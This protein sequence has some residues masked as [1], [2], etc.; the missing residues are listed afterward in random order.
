MEENLGLRCPANTMLGE[1]EIKRH[2]QLLH[3]RMWK[4]QSNFTLE[5][6]IAQHR[7]AFVSMQAAA[8]HVTYQLPNEH[9]RVEYLLDAIQCNDAGPDGQCQDRPSNQWTSK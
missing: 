8:E 5:R 7:S 6:F 3:M 1:A 4:G 2:E 9:S